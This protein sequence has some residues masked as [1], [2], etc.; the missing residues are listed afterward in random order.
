M[1]SAAAARRLF[2]PEVI[3][4]SAMDCGP[5]SL[6][7]L[8]QGFGIDVGYGRLREACQTAV[9][10]TSIDVLEDVANQL[11]LEAEQ[12]M[13][14]RDHI[15]LPESGALPAMVVVQR[16]HAPVH[17]VVVWRRHGRLVQVMD[18]GIGRRWIPQEAFLA[19]L[20]NHRQRVPANDWREYAGSEAFLRSLGRRLAAL[21]LSGR[22]SKAIVDRACQ[23]PGWRTLAAL[24]AST[25]MLDEAMR[26][27]GVSRGD[28]LERILERLVSDP[29]DQAIPEVFWSVRP[30]DR[31]EW[32]AE[33][34]LLLWGA[35]L[36]SVRGVAG[37]GAPAER[38]EASPLPPDLLA[39]M[40]QPTPPPWREMVRTVRQNG[41]LDPLAA[42]VA[43][44]VAAGAVVTEALL[45]RG[46]LD[47]GYSLGI[48]P[49]R[50]G[51][52]GAVVL[53]AM[54]S[55]MVNVSLSAAL[56]R[57]GRKFEVRLRAAFLRKIPRIGDHYFHSRLTSEMADRSHMVP[58]LRTLPSF[59][60][61]L[62]GTSMQMVFTI[63]GLIWLESACAPAAIT[64]A[65]VTLALALGTQSLLGERDLRA[66]SHS[67]SLVRYYLDALLGLTA[68]RAHGAERSLQREHE[69]LLV[70]WTGAQLGMQRAVVWID[71]LQAIAALGLA[72]WLVFGHVARVGQTGSV[73]LLAYWALQ[74][75]TLGQSLGAQLRQLPALRNVMLRMLEP[76]SAPEEATIES[77]TPAPEPALAQAVEAPPAVVVVDDLPLA[78][79]GTSLVRATDV[80]AIAPA[81]APAPRGI[82]VEMEN[83]SVHA[84][85][86]A[87]LEGLNL[88]IEP[89]SH[90]AIVGASGAGKSTLVGLLLGWHRLAAGSLRV[91]GQPLD[92]HRIAWLRTQTAWVDPAIHLYNRGL[93]ANL[94]FGV[95]DTAASEMGWV[96]DAAELREIVERLPEGLQTSLGEGGA[97]V[98]GGEGQ[99]IRLGRAM[100]RRD[101][102]LVILDEPFRGLDRDRRSALLRRT[103][104]LWSNATLVCITHDV[105]ETQHFP[106]VIVLQDGKVVEDG[107]PNYLAA[108]EGSRYAAMLTAERDV[109]EGLWEGGAWRKIWV[110][111][112]RVVDTTAATRTLTVRS[113]TQRMPKR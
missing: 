77:A 96:I 34:H 88:D 50:L 42:L 66:R 61:W 59:L 12:I 108:L 10:G 31:E 100:L 93:A 19:E 27:G 44:G 63:I 58:V 89:S 14:P 102:R 95:D 32:E 111:H 23:D 26:A 91:E 2:A 105:G 101:A 94:T 103:R 82:H 51:A 67:G 83:V 49:Q 40:T 106:R 53:F 11:G 43:T 38:T 107:D 99:R 39:V 8:L 73:L 18:P 7:C 60:G 110:E 84:N 9:D 78:P 71:A 90:L 46:L 97:L 57:I 113:P 76:L 6:K 62:L 22:T 35:V 24:D 55:V 29:D 4:S 47:V 37:K 36:L 92:E 86:H 56:L 80:G 112:G 68:L 30:S 13:L 33:D 21:G 75:P 104:R 15:L 45:F 17:F 72:A 109:R 28:R 1:S 85:G 41:L 65:V 5:A 48:A 54:A 64:A 16:P 20:Y 3:Q 52:M 70:H 25:R 87:L 69:A 74:L 79:T 98:S 81:A